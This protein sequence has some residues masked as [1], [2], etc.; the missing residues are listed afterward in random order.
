MASWLNG[1]GPRKIRNAEDLVT[2]NEFA[3]LIDKHAGVVDFM[4]QSPNG[5]TWRKV[6][7]QAT[8]LNNYGYGDASEKWIGACHTPKTRDAGTF[9]SICSE[10]DIKF[11]ISLDYGET[12]RCNYY[13]TDDIFGNSPAAMAFPV[14]VI[15]MFTSNCVLYIHIKTRKNVLAWNGGICINIA[16]RKEVPI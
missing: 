16:F 7:D 6:I 13:K 3:P 4:K 14:C 9:A 1:H 10:N 2:Q 5:S 8:D 11:L 15:F 12:G